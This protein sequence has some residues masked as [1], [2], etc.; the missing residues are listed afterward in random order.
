[1]PHVLGVSLGGR[2][3]LE[4]TRRQWARSV[5]AIAPT[6]PLTPPERAY[7]AAML[8]SARLGFSALAPVAGR[9]LRWSVPRTAALALPAG[10][11]LAH[12][13]R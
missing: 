7:Q 13:G 3:A 5:A 6:G 9:L 10:Q 11:G 12:A 2:I 8:V 4:L 1:M